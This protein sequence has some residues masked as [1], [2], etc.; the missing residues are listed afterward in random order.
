MRFSSGPKITRL[1]RDKQEIVDIHANCYEWKKERV[2]GRGSA[3]ASFFNSPPFGSPQVSAGSHIYLLVR[4]RTTITEVFLMTN[5]FHRT[6]NDG[7][8]EIRKLRILW[9]CGINRYME[10]FT[11]R[12]VIP[13]DSNGCAWDARMFGR[14][15]GSM[16]A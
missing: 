14:L 2:R 16:W 4:T 10:S 6:F 9:V 13:Q 12:Y 15:S 5:Y 11:G 3:L 8:R 7:D 1:G